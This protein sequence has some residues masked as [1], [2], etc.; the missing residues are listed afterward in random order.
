MHVC[1]RMKTRQH[2][3]RECARRSVEMVNDACIVRCHA[4][5]NVVIGVRVVL[6]HQAINFPLFCNFHFVFK[7]SSCCHAVA[8]QHS[9]YCSYFVHTFRT[10]ETCHLRCG[11]YMKQEVMLIFFRADA[12]FASQKSGTNALLS[13]ATSQDRPKNLHF[14][15]PQHSFRRKL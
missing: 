4:I 10:A 13:T 1:V 11:I 9:F 6:C 12:I 14:C 8:I 5:I 15:A 2:Y 7:F 3:L